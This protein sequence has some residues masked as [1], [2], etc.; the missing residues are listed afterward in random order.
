[1]PGPTPLIKVAAW[2]MGILPNPPLSPD[3]VDFI[4]QPATVDTGPLLR[5][6]PRTLTRLETGLATYLGPRH[7]TLPSSD[8]RH[9]GLRPAA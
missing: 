6:M 2:A 5:V 9:E 8:R 4:N 7:S 3:A 1:M